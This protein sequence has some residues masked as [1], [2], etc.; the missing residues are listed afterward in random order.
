M[1]ES[2]NP[3]IF[4][5]GV[6]ALCAWIAHPS[7]EQGGHCGAHAVQQVEGEPQVQRVQ[8]GKE[9]PRSVCEGCGRGRLSRG[10]S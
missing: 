5:S 4:T 9:L 7:C 3:A 2:G 6:S 10:G 1:L 8:G